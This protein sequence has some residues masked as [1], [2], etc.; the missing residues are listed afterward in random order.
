MSL[1]TRS[2]YEILPNGIDGVLKLKTLIYRVVSRAGISNGGFRSYPA[3]VGSAAPLDAP[4]TPR[5]LEHPVAPAN[6][7]GLPVVEPILPTNGSILGI[8]RP[9]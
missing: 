2:Q 8:A 3:E 9:L 7:A 4:V 5:V 6:A 1:L